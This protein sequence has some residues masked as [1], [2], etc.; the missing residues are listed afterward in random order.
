M[1]LQRA[2]QRVADRQH[3]HDRIEAEV[4]AFHLRVRAGYRAIAAAEPER[5]IVVDASGGMAEIQA[6]IRRR[7]EA[8]LRA[9]AAA[10]GSGVRASG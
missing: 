2:T 8:L 9:T 5:V 3:G 4:L 10:A 7:V 1:G 6:H